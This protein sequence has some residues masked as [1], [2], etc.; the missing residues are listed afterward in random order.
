VPVQLVDRECLVGKPPPRVE[1]V[2][3]HLRERGEVR[4]PASLVKREP[5]LDIRLCA[6]QAIICKLHIR[7]FSHRQNLK[8][9]LFL[10][11][12][13]HFLECF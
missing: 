7:W 9:A 2:N 12:G 10:S 6:L 8:Q 4:E 1:L 13:T 11:P 3:E 5:G